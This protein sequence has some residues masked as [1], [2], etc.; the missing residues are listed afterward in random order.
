MH[1]ARLIV[2]FPASRPGTMWELDQLVTRNW[3][4]KT[5]FIDAPNERTSLY[6][7]AVDW[8]EIGRYLASHEYHL[9]EEDAKGRLI[10][11]GESKTPQVVEPLDFSDLHALHRDLVRVVQLSDSRDFGSA[12]V[13][14]R[15]IRH[16]ADVKLRTRF[17][18]VLLSLL[19]GLWCSEF[20][21]RT[22]RK[23]ARS[24]RRTASVPGHLDPTYRNRRSSYGSQLEYA[25][26]YHFV[27]DGAPYVGHDLVTSRPLDMTIFDKRVIPTRIYFDPADPSSSQAENHKRYSRADLVAILVLFGVMALG[28]FIVA[29]SVTWDLMLMGVGLF[30]Q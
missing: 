8:A 28:G 25:V 14:G 29:G 27:V 1:H 2:L 6:R 7:Q 16:P 23:E 4:A 15:L 9:P 13:S 24:K 3:I 11:F 30:R 10:A 22:F 21:Y 19:A 17:A 18:I 20:L 12:E 26:S 5:V